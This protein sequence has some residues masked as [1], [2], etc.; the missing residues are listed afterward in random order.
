VGGVQARLDRLVDHASVLVWFDSWVS[1][2][3]LRAVVVG[4]RIGLR[5]AGNVMEGEVIRFLGVGSGQGRGWGGL[6]W[7]APLAVVALMLAGSAQVAVAA[8]PHASIRSIPHGL[9]FVCSTRVAPHRVR[10]DARVVTHAHSSVPL[11]SGTPPA[12]A[13]SPAQ[14]EHGYRF[15]KI[16]CG[17]AAASTA[18][19]CG[20]GETIAIVDAYDAPQIAS[21]LAAFDGQYGLPACTTANGCF[22]KVMPQGQP[23]YNSGWEEE[24]SLDVEWAHAI[25]P[26]A[27]ILL[28]EAADNTYAN[29]YGAVRDAVS[30]GATVVSMSWGGSE[31]SGEMTDDSNFSGAGT[32]FVASAGDGGH[33]TDYPAASPNVIA[34][35]GT[36]LTLDSGGNRTSE[37]AWSC[38]SSISCNLFGGTGGD[39]ST[40]EAQPS[41]QSSFAS[42]TGGM[43]GYA[44]VSYDANPNTGVAIDDSGQGGWLQI[45]GT[46]MGAPQWSALVAIAKSLTSPGTTINGA[47]IYAAAYPGSAYAADYN[48]ITSGQN[49]S[50]GSACNA[51]VGWDEPTGLGSPIANSLVSALGGTVTPPPAN[52][53]S[54]GA[55]PGSLTIAQG[56]SGTATISTAV[57]SG[58]AGTVGLSASVSPSG[59]TATLNPASVSAGGSSTLT[60]KPGSAAA[61]SYTVTVTGTEG[62]T[63][64]ATTLTLTVT[65]APPPPS[66]IVNGGFETGTLSGWTVTG[67]ADSVVGNGCHTGSYCAQL[68]SASPTSGSSNIVQTFTVPSGAT[69]LWFFYKG[70]CPDTVKSAWATATLKDTTRRTTTTVLPKTCTNNGSW[71][72]VSSPV[73]AGHSYTLTL[74]SRDDNDAGDGNYTLYDDV[75]VQ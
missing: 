16:G 37:T 71:V 48:D 42:Q 38:S 27:K 17:L 35:G 23:A 66:A 32:T 25:A 8:P 11:A 75:S 65:A 62:S 72:K 58:S 69:S 73:T 19:L 59:P 12:T 29:L 61:G 33:V 9:A 45:G 46:S 1:C 36:T 63:T 70:A 5:F 30:K 51:G 55:T 39:T 4:G 20:T 57:T 13:Y 6:R 31:Y 64:H 49:G 56:S 68:G 28:E 15:D 18:T 21:D 26:G 54:I 60:V 34:V 3:I 22:E 10:C 50:C 14:I 44:D 40:Y 24:I 52:D 2:R 43:R 53:F 47:S 67:P 41:W 7:L 74:T